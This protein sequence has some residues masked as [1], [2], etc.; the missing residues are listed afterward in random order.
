MKHFVTHTT[1]NYE[2]ITLNLIESVR[3]YSK[4]PIR[5]YTIDYEGSE[6][7]KEHAEC[8]RLN[9]NLPNLSEND[10]VKENGNSYVQ[11]KTLRTFLT[12]SSKIDSL[13]HACENGIDEWVYLDSDCIANYNVDDLF[14]YCQT[15]GEYPLASLGPRE[16]LTVIQPDGSV[17]GNPW[18]R[19]DGT[20]D[21][22]GTLEW[23]LMKFFQMD[24]HQRGQYCT[25]NIIVGNST[26]LPFLKLWKNTKDLISS[27]PNFYY[28]TP[29][30]E[31]TIYNVL[32]WRDF[33]YSKTLPM[34][35]I[36]VVGSETLEHFYANEVE[37]D[38]LVT[39]FYMLPKN[40]NKIK[41]FHGEKRREEVE[42]IF[43]LIDKK[44]NKA[45][46][47]LFLAPHLST[48]GMPGFLLRRLETI[49]EFYPSVQLYVVEFNNLSNDYVVQKNRIRELIPFENFFT[50]SDNKM[51]LIDIIKSNQIDI[52][53]IDEMSESLNFNQTSPSE[54]INALYDNDRTWRVI[55]TCHNVSFQPHLNK[56]FNPDAYAFCSPWHKEKSFSMMN[57]FAKVIEFPI[58]QKFTDDESKNKA[59]DKL[60][61][62]KDKKHIVNIGL[63]TPGKNQSEGL[64]IAKL[65]YKTNPDLHFHFVGNLAPNFERYWGSLI[66]KL[67]PNVTVWGERSDASTFIEACDIFM[68]N[69]TW[70]CN[71]L[72]LREAISYGKKI[73]ARN[74]KEYLGMFDGYIFPINDDVNQTTEVIQ[75]LLNEQ[76]E[77]KVEE[78]QS[79]KFADS[80]IELYNKVIKKPSSQHKVF[81][82]KVKITNHYIEQ[83]F[84][85]ITGDSDS[86]YLIKFF[87]EHGVC[88]YENTL[89]SNHWIKLS[90]KYYTKWRAMVWEDGN[91]IYDKTLNYEN[92]RVYIA[93]DSKSL[94]DSV[95]WIP[96]ALEFQKK[97]KCKVIVSTFWNQLFE[98]SYPEL[99]FIS[100]GQVAHGILGMYKIGWFYDPLYEKE[101]PNTIPLQKA[102]TNILGLDFKEIKPKVHLEDLPKPI[103][104]KYVT[105]ATNSTAGL[106]F[107]TREGWQELVNYLIDKGYSVVNVSKEDNPFR[108]VKKLKDTSIENTMNYIHHSE[109]FIGLSSGLS[110]LSWGLGKQVVMISNFTEENHEF[111]SNCI[112]I[113]NKSVCNGCWNN[114]DFQFDRGDWNWCPV[115]KGTPRQF[116][117]HT[118]IT[119]KNVID[120]I[121]PLLDSRLLNFDWGWMETSEMGRFHKNEIT[122]ETFQDR[123]YE[124]FFE[125]EENDVVIDV[126]AS[127][128]PFTYSVLDKKPNV[129]L[130]LEPSE[131][132][133]RTLVKNTK[134]YPVIPIMKGISRFDGKTTNDFIYSSDKNMEGI[135][136]L[137]LT[138]LYDLKKID[139]LKTDCEGG[140]YD[141]FT[142]QNFDFIQ[143][144][145]KKISGEWHLSNSDLK[146][147][148]KNFRDTFL[149][150]FENFK[151]FSVD[152]VDIKWDLWNDHFIDFYTEVIIYIDNR[153]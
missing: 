75:K 125:V 87:D 103:E 81:A 96:Y 112:R 110:W 10:F 102:A 114:P 18:W 4:N 52:V 101:K 80:H 33:D 86:D 61:L 69:S 58:D 35:Y 53:H 40:K 27:L 89:K 131:K 116:E 48:G 126:G 46:K 78:G 22:E 148:F 3:K 20:Y 57:S 49:K 47:V 13:I 119:S 74:L 45:L 28:Y 134:G 23:P 67:P 19:E 50:L 136:F 70:E 88:H 26:T 17:L 38:T 43:D 71:P 153:K 59:L 107:W 143:K 36:N 34:S 41:V 5:V 97:H 60:G 130:S 121:Q 44:S 122:K 9:L 73:I 51:E 1:E 32:C 77:Y 14:E 113:I 30:H 42:K 65:M 132:E 133:F 120:K 16:V 21:P 115:H 152:G 7:L 72:V 76:I 6:V 12:L 123:I 64:K 142:E 66:K 128:G 129:V 109:F 84:L 55:E 95:A 137:K 144:N 108:G 15:V 140:E 68:F 111:T 139:F 135:S 149:S 104:E 31:E 145:V 93:F 11:R 39:A 8:I 124:R 37:E 117:C 92:Q 100:P 147:K 90:R 99:E 62:D 85:E 118:S 25:T 79:R 63:W 138:E 82:S 150:K 56:I 91:L 146:L 141:I 83:P 94:G 105:I 98:K 151:V 2:L 24:P 54:L 106:K 127:V 29:L